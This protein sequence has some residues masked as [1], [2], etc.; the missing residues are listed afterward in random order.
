MLMLFLAERGGSDIR[1]RQQREARAL[2]A[3]LADVREAQEGVPARL[4]LRDG[5][6]RLGS[7]YSE[8]RHCNCKCRSSC[9]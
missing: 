5:D 9:N 2:V 3:R 6:E 4:V 1:L 7:E 8:S